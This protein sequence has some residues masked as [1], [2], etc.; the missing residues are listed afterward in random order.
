MLG[1]WDVRGWGDVSADKIRIEETGQVFCAK[2][3]YLSSEENLN[4]L[5]NWLIIHTL[6]INLQLEIV[7]E[8]CSVT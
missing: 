7:M 8:G 4:S 6:Y 2:N 3:G 5:S 1:V